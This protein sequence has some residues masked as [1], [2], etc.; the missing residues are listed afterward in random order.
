[1]IYE[2]ALEPEMVATWGKAHNHRFFIRE[3]GL[4]QGRQVSR[5]PKTWARKVWEV[6]VGGSELERKR[7]EELLARM[8]ETMVK[9]KQ[10]CWD[11]S[12]SGWLEN[13]LIEHNRY[14][15]RGILARNNPGDL[16][17]I[18]SEDDLANSQH[19]GWDVPHGIVVNRKA[20]EM[21]AAIGMML[22]CCRWVKF[23]DPHL[24]PGR[25][26]YR[27]SLRA[28]MKILAIGRSVGQP[29]SVEIHTGRHEGTED[30]L[31]DSYEKIIPASLLVTIFQWEEKP[32]GQRLHNRYVLT[33]IGGVSFQHGLDTGA[34]GETDDIT[35][36]D[37][38][39]YILRCKQY[40]PV[41]PAFDQAALPIEI[42]G[43]G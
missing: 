43:S 42:V 37:R 12:K 21:V 38:E 25:P 30:F 10:Y 20:P 27:N 35:R 2:Y 23:I 6:F 14:P 32:S 9:R 3:F 8:K 19:Q 26:D 33:D 5:Y 22:S 13:A 18:I 11:E 41:T 34:E 24:S 17:E 31:R 39:Q 29:E 36:L 16:T 1:M 28:F 4:G 7:L 40:D 15:F